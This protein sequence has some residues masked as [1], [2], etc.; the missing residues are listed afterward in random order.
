MG[1]F[2][3]KSQKKT[4]TQKN[5]SETI[6]VLGGTVKADKKAEFLAFCKEAMANTKSAAGCEWAKACVDKEDSAKFAIFQKWK[7]DASRAA[8]AEKVKS[9]GKLKNAM[10]TMLEPGSY[11]KRVFAPYSN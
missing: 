2:N 9:E 3:I 5:M 10:E 7:D 8:F 6:V 4:H 1:R 11:K